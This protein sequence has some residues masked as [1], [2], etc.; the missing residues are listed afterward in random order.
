MADTKVRLK[1]ILYMQLVA[2]H[3]LMRYTAMVLMTN[4]AHAAFQLCSC[5]SVCG[6]HVQRCQTRA[7]ISCCA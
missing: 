2:P 6:K 5:L 1:Y 3:A 7:Q 4:C